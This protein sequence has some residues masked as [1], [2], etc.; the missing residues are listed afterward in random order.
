MTEEI[1]DNTKELE[2]VENAEEQD[3]TE[4]DYKPMALNRYQYE[5]A[6][7]SVFEE[8][9]MAELF[10]YCAFGLAGE[11]GEYE[12]KIAKSYRDGM[13][14][15]TLN[16]SLADE[17]GDILWF[18][19]MNAACLGYDL[20]NIAMRNLMKLAKRQAEGTLGGNGDDR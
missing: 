12:Q 5:A 15:A 3:S 18:V 11:V 6:Q 2:E 17:L 9:Q 14:E 4:P 8:D 13:D 16:D 10:M 19:A 20:E 7:T 1:K